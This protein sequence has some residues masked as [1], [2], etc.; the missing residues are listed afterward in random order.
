MFMFACTRS[1]AL[2]SFCSHRPVGF[3]LDS[4][5]WTWLNSKCVFAAFK[6]PLRLSTLSPSLLHSL[7]LERRHWNLACHQ[8][9]MISWSSMVSSVWGHTS[10]AT[11]FYTRD[12][13]K[14]TSSISWGI[15]YAAAVYLS[16]PDYAI[17]R[18]R[19]GKK[20]PRMIIQVSLLFF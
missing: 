3:A 20:N 12:E 16:S 6:H 9:P 11:G 18:V 8:K 5:R 10:A 17:N 14:N 4:T 7:S 15:V 13:N 19:W 2:C 1:P